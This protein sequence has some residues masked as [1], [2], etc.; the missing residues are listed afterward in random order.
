MFRQNSFGGASQLSTKPS[1]RND[2]QQENSGENNS[3][4]LILSENPN[5][6]YLKSKGKLPAFSKHQVQKGGK[7]LSIWN[8][9]LRNK[10]WPFNNVDFNIKTG[11]FLISD[12]HGQIYYFQLKDSLNEYESVKLASKAVSSIAFLQGIK[13]MIILCYENGT[14]VVMNIKTKEIISNIQLPSGSKTVIKLIKSHPK[15]PIIVFV[16]EDNVV[17]LWN[18]E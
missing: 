4:T 13:S 1:F 17:S 12:T 6:V 16:T 5:T 8:Y 10:L 15:K 7:L 11:N 3:D 18:L 2:S 9:P 14:I